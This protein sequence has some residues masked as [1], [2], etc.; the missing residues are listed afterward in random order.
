MFHWEPDPIIFIATLPIGEY[1][2][3]FFHLVGQ[4]I[5]DLASSRIVSQPHSRCLTGYCPVLANAAQH[6]IDILKQKRS[7]LFRKNLG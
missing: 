4:I 5:P 7:N 2:V 6:P 3:C 1:P